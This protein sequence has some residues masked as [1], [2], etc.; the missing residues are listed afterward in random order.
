MNRSDH[1]DFEQAQL[2]KVW[3]KYAGTV[4][5]NI[6]AAL[7]DRFFAPSADNVANSA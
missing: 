5:D 2:H 7:R 4:A 6:W 3:G 1:L